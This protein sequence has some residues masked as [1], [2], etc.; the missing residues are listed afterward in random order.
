MNENDKEYVN[1][2]EVVAKVVSDESKSE[3]NKD[4]NNEQNKT[5][6]DDLVSSFSTE[7]PEHLRNKNIYRVVFTPGRKPR[8]RDYDKNFFIVIADT[9]AEAKIEA[10]T[11]VESMGLPFKEKF[12]LFQK[13]T[14]EEITKSDK[15]KDFLSRQKNKP[16]NT[17]EDLT[18]DKLLN[19]QDLNTLDDDYD[20]GLY[21]GN[22]GYKL[23]T[24]EDTG[25]IVSITLTGVN[26]IDQGNFKKYII[27]PNNSVKEYSSIEI[28]AI[29]P[30]NALIALF[31]IIT[32]VKVF[33]QIYALVE[34]FTIQDVETKK[35]S[36]VPAK[37]MYK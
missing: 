23:E 7:L 30:S 32:S 22:S 33:E 31:K 16:N 13:D 9:L 24:D 11:K 34:S 27:T 36:I 8:K 26:I 3:S 10:K 18:T 28:S 19:L 14:I 17:S 21:T 29:S 4:T 25:Q 2:I 20:G 35:V 1:D 37:L 15:F 12:A 5:S 6:K